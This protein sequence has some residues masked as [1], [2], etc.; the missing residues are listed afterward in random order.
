MR[1]VVALLFLAGS[2]VGQQ[3]STYSTTQVDI[4]G[5]RSASPTEVTST[6]SKD[7]SQA[8]ERLASING[9]MVPIE[10]VQEKI[11]RDDASGRSVERTVQHFDPTGNAT[12]TEKVVIEEQKS[13]NGSATITSTKY[14]TDVNGRMQMTERSVTSK[15]VN[16]DSTTS[17]S[18]IERATEDGRFGVVE[19]RNAVT[20]KRSN[21]YDESEMTYRK[22]PNGSFYPAVR[23]V[24]DHTES[25]GQSSDNTAEYETGAQG[26]L[27]LHSQTAARSYKRADG[28]VDNEVDVFSRDVPGVVNDSSR[29]RLEEHQSIE[30][31]Q[32]GND[33]V[34]S[35]SVRRPTVSDPNTLGP[36]RQISQT[37][38][39]GACK[40]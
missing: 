16:G 21:G 20:V 40:P 8:T 11:L 14:G 25:S 3:T 6:K 22:D 38:C 34:E 35:V 29:L 24:T 36:A 12:N 10:R 13:P 18:V 4:N 19:K 30:R 9:R 33:V 28:S 5:Y 15:Q 2:V 7:G 39:H 37:V 31:R 17:D 32:Q 1:I 23:R 27:Q 26:G